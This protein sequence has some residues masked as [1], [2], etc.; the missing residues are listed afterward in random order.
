MLCLEPSYNAKLP[1][2]WNI[3]AMQS[4][5]V[6]GTFTNCKFALC[7]RPSHEVVLWLEPSN[8][9]TLLCL[10]PSHNAKLCCTVHSCVVSWT[11][12]QYIVTLCLD[13]SQNANLCSAWDLHT[14]Q[15]G[16]RQIEKGPLFKEFNSPPTYLVCHVHLIANFLVFH[17]SLVVGMNCGAGNVWH[18]FEISIY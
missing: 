6:H 16:E 4:C 17:M 9:V 15:I 2:A 10:K 18:G 8:S 7:L 11:F 12:T 5:V 13:P 3:H 14:M 1:Y